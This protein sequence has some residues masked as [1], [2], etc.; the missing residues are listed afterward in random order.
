MSGTTAQDFNYIVKYDIE[1]NDGQQDSCFVRV[2][3]GNGIPRIEINTNEGVAIT[4]KTEYVN[5]HIKISNCPDNGLI[6]SDCK[7]RGRGNATW[8]HPKKSYKFKFSEKQSPFG[9]PLTKILC[10]LLIILIDLSSE[11]LICA[12]F[13]EH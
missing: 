13:Q 7:I 3:T 6:E 5:A 10:Y 8:G 9:F 1:S 11:L 2:L 12:K 4:S